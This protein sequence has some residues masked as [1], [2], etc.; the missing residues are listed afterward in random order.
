MKKFILPFVAVGILLFISCQTEP[1]TTNPRTEGFNFLDNKYNQDHKEDVLD[2]YRK[3]DTVKPAVLMIH[4]C[5]WMNILNRS[6]IAPDKDLFLDN[7]YHVVNIDHQKIDITNPEGKQPTYLDMLNDV[8]SA[9]EYI[10]DRSS[11]FKID[12]SYLVMYGYSSGAHLAELYSYKVTDSPIPVRLCIAKGG[13]ADFTN[14]KFRECDVFGFTSNQGIRSEIIKI[15]KN[16][17]FPMTS[18]EEREKIPESEL[19]NPFRVFIVKTLLGIETDETNDINKIAD[20]PNNQYSIQDASPLYHVKQKTTNEEISK[21]PD[22]ILLHGEQDK[23]VDISMA[24]DLAETLGTAKC[25]LITMPNSGHDLCDP[26]DDAKFQEFKEYVEETIIK[27]N[28]K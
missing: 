7:G 5:A 4:G 3:D 21:I 13:P 17:C 28:Q 1:V 11:D 14:P 12:T 8:K 24:N 27:L 26:S 19:S 9:V 6:S 16:L 2:V 25:K 18:A 10:Y 23:L 22:T 20:D 15:I